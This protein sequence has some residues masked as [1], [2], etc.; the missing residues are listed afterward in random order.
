MT[1]HAAQMKRL[2]QLLHQ[3]V[4]LTRAMGVHAHAYDGQILHFA[5]DFDPN[6]NIHGTAFGGSL[7]S[8]CAVT[9]WALLQLALDRQDVQVLNVLESATMTYHLPVREGPIESRCRMPDEG[10]FE[11]YVADIRAGARAWLDL[12]AEVM[13][14]RR[15]A[16]TF[17][18][19]YTAKP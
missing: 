16:A 1:E 5:T 12:T 17:N 13:S 7:Y 8:I 2:E 3:E 19:H 6:I 14:G 15:V 18:G 9:C 4:P 10:Q 11:A